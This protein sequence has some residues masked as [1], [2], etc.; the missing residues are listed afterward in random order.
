MRSSP[1]PTGDDV[2]G[3]FGGLSLVFSLGFVALVGASVFAA[4]YLMSSSALRVAT[5]LVGPVLGL[6]A[7]DAVIRLL[8]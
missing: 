4:R 8:T 3:L 6:F 1:R 2:D 5:I 7:I